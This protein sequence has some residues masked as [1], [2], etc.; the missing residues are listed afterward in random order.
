MY[1]SANLSGRFRCQL[2]QKNKRYACTAHCL[3]AIMVNE[4]TITFDDLWWWS[5]SIITMG[6][7]VCARDHAHHIQ[8]EPVT[9]QYVFFLCFPF[10]FG[11]DFDL[12]FVS[13][14]FVS[15]FRL[16]VCVPACAHHILFINSNK[17]LY[18]MRLALFWFKCLY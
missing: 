6:K 8:T 17:F 12:C 13:I 18:F 3:F 15:F 11:F 10:S 9:V 1:R 14:F 7:W 5:P 4:Q 2:N 16:F